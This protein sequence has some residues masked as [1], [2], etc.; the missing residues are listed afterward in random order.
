MTFNELID[1][2]DDSL[3]PII[4]KELRQ[5]VRGRFLWGVLLLFLGFQCAV[6]SVSIADRGMSNSS[7]G[8]DTLIFL[9]VILF[10]GCFA[11]IPLYSGFKFAKERGENSEELLLITT[12]TPYSVI[13]GKFAA[14]M[15]FILLIF[16]AFAPFMAMTFFLSGVDMPLMFL[17]LFLGLLVCGGATML[18]IALGSLAHDLSAFNLLRGVGLFIQI[19]LFFSLIG[20]VSEIFRFGAA[21]M[22]GTSQFYEALGTMIFFILAATYFLY[23]AAAAVISPSGSNRMLPLRRYLT[24]LWLISLAITFYWII[25][26]SKASLIY[27][28]GFICVSVL[29]FMLVIAVSERD[30]LTRRVARDI[31]KGWLQNRLA[32][33]LS[34]GAAGGITWC[35]TM[36]VLTIIVVFMT[37]DYL[38]T[39]AYV[40]ARAEFFEFAFG[41]TSY[42]LAYTLLAAFIRRVFLAE[43]ISI[44]N[45]WVV[46]L[47][48]CAV[49]SIAPMFL[50]IL[51][52]SGSDLLMVGNPF[53]IASSRSREVGIIFA[54]TMSV[55][56][57]IVNLPWLYRQAREFF[58]LEHNLQF[59]ARADS[60]E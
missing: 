29:N 31:P 39:G 27:G 53:S 58:A 4:V 15:A 1:R 40:Y 26:G 18:Q 28:W 19:S 14:S 57:L 49:F 44:R 12:I 48:V 56:G 34:S 9:F 50:G 10:V 45:T 17:V 41:F 6:L 43:Y 47:I 60:E 38:F 20:I 30:Y 3:N 35:L 13:R 52:G 51:A 33:L 42:I 54:A 7:V 24:R 21:R 46:A 59:E 22:F 36:I 25:T 16:S 2:I 32:F 5:V 11:V 23:L 8:A 55:I 37:S